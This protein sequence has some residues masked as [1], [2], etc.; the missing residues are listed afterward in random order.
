MW[1]LNQ[2]LPFAP[3]ASCVCPPP[4]AQPGPFPEDRNHRLPKGETSRAGGAGR[5]C[6]AV[7]SSVRRSSS[8]ALG[9]TGRRI[10]WWGGSSR[11][12]QGLEVFGAGIAHCAWAGGYGKGLD[13]SEE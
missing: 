4:C 10:S 12:E 8:P 2:A 3:G 1:S 5:L 11:E 7:S 13:C 9:C 6:L